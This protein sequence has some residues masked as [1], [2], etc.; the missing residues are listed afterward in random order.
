MNARGVVDSN[1]V[2]F[3]FLIP[4]FFAC[5]FSAI[6]SS[7]GQS[8]VTLSFNA[9]NPSTGNTTQATFTTAENIQPGR[10]DYQQGGFQIIGWLIS[11]GIGSI[12]GIIIGLLYKCLNSHEINSDIND[13]F[14][15]AALFSYPK[16]SVAGEREQ[17]K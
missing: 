15:D 9:T 5:I 14:N 7:F 2:V 16:P 11:V 4:S 8:A 13:F 1:S 6:L 12:G 17:A 10:S 3:H